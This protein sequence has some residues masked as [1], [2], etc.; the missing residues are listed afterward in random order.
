MKVLYIGGTGEISY[1]CV[2]ASLREGHEVVVFNRG[3]SGEPLP[4]GVRQ[5]TGDMNDDVAYAKLGDE[6]FDVVCQ[7]L[8]F[9]AE[10]FDRDRR[11]FGGKVSQ[12][13]LIST[14]SAYRKPPI[15]HVITEKTALANPFWPYSAKKIEM[16]QAAMA[17]HGAGELPVTIVRPSH[18]YRRKFPGTFIPGDQIAARMMHGRPVI[19]HGDG[20]SLWVLTHADD[21]AAAFVRLLGQNR[22]LGEAYHITT[23]EANTWDRIIAAIAAALGVEA[24]IVHVPSDTLA[25]YDPDARGKLLGDKACSV[26]FDNTKVRQ[27]VGGRR[28]HVEMWD[29]MK[30]VVPYVRERMAVRMPDPRVDALV[31]RIIAEQ[32][33]L[34]A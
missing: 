26:I 9:D 19:V 23:D 24:K 22:T 25:R 12:Y 27:A 6:G 4:D 28:A 13:V 34:G 15:S 20:Q 5:I 32:E 3:S 30:R 33:A 8:A 10:Q 17:A 21:F 14:A 11:V 16:E 18:T 1:A 2:H 7:F 31:D 29:G